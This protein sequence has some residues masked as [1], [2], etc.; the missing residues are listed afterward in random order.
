MEGIRTPRELS[1]GFAMG[2][3]MERVMVCRTYDGF[4]QVFCGFYSGLVMVLR[5]L[6]VGF[7]GPFPLPTQPSCESKVHADAPD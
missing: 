3:S 2:I 1:G 7:R 5:G 6:R 4:T